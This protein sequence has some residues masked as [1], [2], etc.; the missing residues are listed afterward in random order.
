MIG[1]L[2]VQPG[3]ALGDMHMHA[4]GTDARIEAGGAA[5]QADI[6]CQGWL[7]TAASDADVA[8][9]HGD[10]GSHCHH[11]QQPPSLFIADAVVAAVLPPAEAPRPAGASRHASHMPAV[12][13]RPPRARR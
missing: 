12:R 2:P 11:C 10:H 9:D 13:S 5:L 4:P 8:Q 6:H 7:A 1:L 3:W